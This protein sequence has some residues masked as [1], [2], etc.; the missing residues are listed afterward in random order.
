MAP[1]TGPAMGGN[2]ALE[3]RWLAVGLI[4]AWGWMIWGATLA[5]EGFWTTG[6][7]YADWYWLDPRGHA[8]WEF[9]NLPT[10]GDPHVAIEA[11]LCLSVPNGSAP[12]EIEVRFQIGTTSGFASRLWAT[13][14]NRI[15]A[16]HDHAMYFGQVFLPRR[17]IGLGSR[18]TVRLDGAQGAILMGVHPNSVRVSVGPG[19]TPVSKAVTVTA[20]GQGGGLEEVVGAVAAAGSST[21]IVRSL[22]PSDAANDAPFLSPGTYRGALGWVG[23]YDVPNGKGLY[24]VNLRAGEVITVRIETGSPCAL[25]LLDPSGR[26]VGEV[27]G[28]SW[29]GLEYRAHTVGAWQVLIVCRE[30]SPRFSYT[31]T[32]NIR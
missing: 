12:S 1:D 26:K 23:P 8:Q 14:L 28:S 17:E 29:L 19:G 24:R 21:S 25:Y 11:F 3:R 5:A 7:G 20:N 15:Q 4:L 13:R 27:E 2:C 6:Q 22:P 31:L 16:N 9:I 32:L 10:G 18:L 30:S